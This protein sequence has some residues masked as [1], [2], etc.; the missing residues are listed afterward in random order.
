MTLKWMDAFFWERLIAL[1]KVNCVEGTSYINILLSWNQISVC[2]KQWVKQVCSTKLIPF[3][4]GF[5]ASHGR[6]QYFF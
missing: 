1:K 2:T 3:F 4:F 5:P 6:S